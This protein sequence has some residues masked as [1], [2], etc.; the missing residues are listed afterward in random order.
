VAGVSASFLNQPLEIAATRAALRHEL[1][2]P[3]F[4]QVVLRLGVGADVPAGKA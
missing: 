4:P 2:L 1:A 3:G